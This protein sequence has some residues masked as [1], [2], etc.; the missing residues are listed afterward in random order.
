LRDRSL[1][2]GDTEG[3]SAAVDPTEFA[4]L[5]RRY[6]DPLFSLCL[7]RLHDRALAEDVVQDAF[8]DAFALL[9]RFDRRRPFWPWLAS[10]AVGDCIDAHRR[11]VAATSSQEKLAGT[12][13]LQSPDDPARAALG[14]LTQEAVVHELRRL[15]PRQRAAMELL[16]FDGWSYAEIADRLGC[17]IGSVK[18]LVVRARATLRR[19]RTRLAGG[20]GGIWR[21]LG[22]RLQGLCKRAVG[23]G[24]WSTS[25]WDTGFR[26][27]E[28]SAA[29]ALVVMGSFLG[30]S[31]PSVGEQGERGAEADAVA[32]APTRSSAGTSPTTSK[33]P[34]PS[35]PAV[36]AS[37]RALQRSVADGSAAVLEGTVSS[38][39]GEEIE[40]FSVS[41]G[42]EED[43]TVFAVDAGRR[44]SVTH[45]GG[46]SWSRLRG[47]GLDGTR[48]LLPPD[49]PR[50][51]RIFALGRAGLQMS[52][53]GGDTFEVVAPG[54]WLDAAVSPGFD[55]GDPTVLLVGA[56]LWRYDSVG[57]QTE[58]VLLDEE[59]A[60]H[61]LVGARYDLAA[62]DSRTVRLLSRLPLSVST[63]PERTTAETH[64]FY[65][66][67]CR[68]PAVSEGPALPGG[69]L[70]A[71]CTT[72]RL[73]D[74]LGA[75]TALVVSPA[76][77]RTIFVRGHDSLLVSS[78]EGRTFRAATP[79]GE[80][81]LANL[82]VA[83]LPESA[84]SLVVARSGPEAGG[85][86][87]LRTDDAGASWTPLHVGLPGF[88]AKSTGAAGARSVTVTPTGRILAGGEYGGIACSA[89]GGRS[90]A[91]LCPT[92]DA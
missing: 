41:P 49:H 55:D 58:P 92:P 91:P 70:R 33:P 30:T 81:W 28:A 40:S 77:S 71:A 31:T 89:D 82:D 32:A 37:S 29:L 2:R 83:V 4:A 13:S 63:A 26:G 11:R 61:V 23:T 53:N 88:I 51:R 7:A 35:E 22:S 84:S 17:S 15:P 87:L 34:P 14:R 42:Y 62:G 76:T 86:A 75:L 64:V 10:I 69:P 56:G 60:G 38:A 68:L 54:N 67:T 85:P 3:A 46:A 66:G 21:G 48:L 45:D 27:I 9:P 1:L 5:Y 72:T 25:T 19:A 59:L 16:A 24:P 50:D 80:P 43:S 8:A 78:D 6:R 12:A 47:A 39:S 57:G 18:L 52:D 44:V 65:V 73:R 79:W 90:W 74:H 36:Q 20:L